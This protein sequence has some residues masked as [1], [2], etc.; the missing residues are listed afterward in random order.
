LVE[1]G[2]L[3]SGRFGWWTGLAPDGSMLALRDIS[4]QEIYALDLKLP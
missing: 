3:V 1:A 4:L 2:P